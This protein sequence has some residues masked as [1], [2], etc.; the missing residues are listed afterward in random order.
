MAAETILAT[1]GAYGR[2]RLSV[3]ASRLA[4]RFGA[5]SAPAVLS[6]LVSDRLAR[7]LS[8]I[9]MAWPWFVRRFLI[10]RWFLH[11]QQ[12]ALLASAHS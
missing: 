11:R 5:G 3:H 12:P 7:S 9:V 8:P 2:E 1:R 6:G 10:D 4:A